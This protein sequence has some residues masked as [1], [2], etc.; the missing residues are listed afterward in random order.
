M[1]NVVSE[2]IVH[3][4]VANGGCIDEFRKAISECHPDRV[5]PAGE[6]EQVA[7]DVEACVKATAA[8]RR[9]FAGNPEVF[10]HQYLRRLDKE[11]DEDL[12]PTPA[13]ME[14]EAKNE[15]RWWTGMRRG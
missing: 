8:L 6:R 12:K 9:C 14:E 3:H 13:Q 1:G 7:V 15:F 10:K 2:V 11:L 4:H 5:L